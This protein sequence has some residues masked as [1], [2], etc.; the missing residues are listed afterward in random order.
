MSRLPHM[1]PLPIQTILNLMMELPY[2]C[3][4]GRFKV[5]LKFDSLH[6]KV[7]W[8]G[9][10]QALQIKGCRCALWPNFTNYSVKS[11]VFF[12]NIW[13][14]MG[15]PCTSLTAPLILVIGV[16]TYLPNKHIIF[17]SLRFYKKSKFGY[18][19]SQKQLYHI[20]RHSEFWF[21]LSLRTF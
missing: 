6:Y 17:M 16:D 3:G 12:T 7:F 21:C 1:E 13:K 14:F 2:C 4:N 9:A 15:W 10:T 18:L 8:S 19:E 11:A 20:Q 5:V